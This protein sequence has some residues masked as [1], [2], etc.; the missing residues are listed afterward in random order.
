MAGMTRNRYGVVAHY[1]NDLI[2]E[3]LAPGLL[4]ELER[5]NPLIGPGYRKTK[6]HQWFDD[7]GEKLFSRQMLT[8]IALQRACLNK[9]GDKSIQFVSMV[10]EVLPKKGMTM[11]LA[12][13][14]VPDRSLP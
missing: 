14:R 6:H 7:D 4:E 5:R 10:N 8:I 13:Q 9:G 3:R 11:P 1:T 2:Y 12:Q